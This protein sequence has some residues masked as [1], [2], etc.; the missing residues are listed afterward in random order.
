MTQT[1]ENNGQRALEDE[2]N[3]PSK[4]PKESLNGGQR[5]R[6]TYGKEAY[7]IVKVFHKMENM[8]WGPNPVT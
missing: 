8:F 7:A 2:R 5:R 6:A 3:E 1:T 4:I